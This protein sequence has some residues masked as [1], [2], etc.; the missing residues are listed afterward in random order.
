MKGGVTM[1]IILGILVAVLASFFVWSAVKEKIKKKKRKKEELQF[2]KDTEQQSRLLIFA[3][4]ILVDKNEKYLKEFEPSIGQYKMSNIINTARGFLEKYQ[5]D[6]LF[7][8][9]ILNNADARDEIFAFGFLRD[10]RS[11]SWSKRC[12]DK[13]QWIE[14]K[15]NSYNISLYEDEYQRVEKRVNDYYD[16]E[17]LKDD[18]EDEST[19]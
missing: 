5:E 7:K 14:E 15:F 19:K 9:C 13:L 6:A 17:F 8:E 18:K 16:A 11:N 3:L 12:A 2:K 10:T 4:K 1:W